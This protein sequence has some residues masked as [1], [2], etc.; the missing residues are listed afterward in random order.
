MFWIFLKQISLFNFFPRF[1][2][3]TNTFGSL[4]D[5]NEFINPE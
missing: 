4:I 2:F 5:L 1:I 3:G